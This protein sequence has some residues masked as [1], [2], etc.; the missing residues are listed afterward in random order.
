MLPALLYPMLTCKPIMTL[1]TYNQISITIYKNKL[2]NDCMDVK[3]NSIKQ[4]SKIY[5]NSTG[6]SVKVAVDRERNRNILTPRSWL[7]PI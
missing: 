7:V 4:S 3:V 2:L 6:P 5:M 1:S